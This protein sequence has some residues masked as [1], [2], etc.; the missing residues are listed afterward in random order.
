LPFNGVIDEVAVYGSALSAARVLA[1]YTNAQTNVTT[2]RVSIDVRADAGGT[3]VNS[4]QLSANE[5]DPRSANNSVTQSVTVTSPTADL[6][7]TGVALPDPVAVGGTLRY[8][9]TVSGAGAASATN[10]SLGATLPSDATFLSATSS[11]GSCSPAA[12]SVTCAIGALAVNPVLADGP[13][14]YW[15]LG[16][17]TS[18]TT[19]ADT[20]GGNPGTYSGVT[21]EAAGAVP[22][23]S[24]AS[25]AGS[26]VVSIPASST[27]NLSSALTVEAWIKPSVA[28]Q[29]AGI[30]EKTVGGTVNTGYLMLIEAGRIE[31]RGKAAGGGYL[32]AIGPFLAAGTWSHVVGTF[33]G[34]TLRLYVNGAQ[35]ASTAA[36]T[37]ASGS[38]PAFIGRLGAEGGNPGILPFNGVIDEVAVYGSALS[39][40]RVL[41]H[42]TGAQTNVTTARVT[43]DVRPTAAGTAT[44]SIQVSADQSDPNPADNTLGLSTLIN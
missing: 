18:A 34:T 1:H 9:A 36:G 28:G 4:A 31:W 21:P 8:T 33:D 30:F 22:G 23:D 32:T 3:L 14:S 35:V 41:A 2:A 16:E 43:I 10:V 19:A 15:R 24:A 39:P 37:L 20:S 12:G 25:F 27:L 5:Q 13:V 17:P 29:N 44:A 38:G 40:A 11:Q 7:V 26:S 42:Y 6:K